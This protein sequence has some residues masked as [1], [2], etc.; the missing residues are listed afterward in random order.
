MKAWPVLCAV[1]ALACLEA[2]LQGP[3]VLASLQWDEALWLNKPWTL[4]TASLAH[5]SGGHLLANLLALA[6]IA[7]LGW[8][9]RTGKAAALALFVAWPLGNLA[10]LAWPE[11]RQYGGLS[12]LIHAAIAV[13]WADAALHRKAWP[14]SYIVFGG[15]ALK[16]LTEHAWTTPIAFDP[17]WGFNVVYAS[18]LTGTLAGAACGIA[19]I[20]WSMRRGAGGH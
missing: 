19:A 15:M 16:L 20:A 10:L 14:L 4:W 8:S 3:A 5:L 9:L 11:V 6:A 13:L 1:L 7:V 17:A 2:W 12:G 18:H